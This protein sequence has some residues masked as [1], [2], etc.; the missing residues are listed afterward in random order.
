VYMYFCPLS[1]S[2]GDTLQVLGWD[3][4][5]QRGHS[6]VV[7]EAD[8]IKLSDPIFQVICH[9]AHPHADAHPSLLP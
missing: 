9:C 1:E 8:R 5:R 7:I 6:A 3:F 2:D 4:W